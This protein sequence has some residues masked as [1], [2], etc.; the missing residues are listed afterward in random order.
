MPADHPPRRSYDD[1]TPRERRAV[2]ALVR[3]TKRWPETLGLFSWAG[4][5]CVIDREP[6]TLAAIDRAGREDTYYDG[7]IRTID[8]IPPLYIPNDGGDPN[9]FD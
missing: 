1:L 2:D 6:E 4:S 5:L 9:E 8:D 7:A 3:L